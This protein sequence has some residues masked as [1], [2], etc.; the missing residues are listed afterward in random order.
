MLSEKTKKAILDLQKL[1]PEKRSALIPACHIAQTEVGY[2]PH[3]VQKEVADLFGIDV[4]EVHAVV[5]FYDMFFEEPVGKH[6]IHVC[7]NVSCMLHGCDALLAKLCE[8]LNVKPGPGNAS[9]DGE[10]TVIASECLA[11][12]DRAPVMLVDDKVEGLVKESDLDQIL[13]NAK[14]SKGHPSPITVEEIYD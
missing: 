1:Y 10:F 12:C 3:D 4:N 2:L 7:K 6:V 8:K 9:A 11:A 13:Q 5:T 14:K